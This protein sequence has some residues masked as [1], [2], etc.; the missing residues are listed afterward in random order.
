MTSADVKRKPH[1]WDEVNKMKQWKHACGAR[2][3]TPELVGAGCLLCGP[4]SW[5]LGVEPG[6]GRVLPSESERPYLLLET[7]MLL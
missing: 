6:V 5:S 3:S 1:L 7:G 4:R 2:G